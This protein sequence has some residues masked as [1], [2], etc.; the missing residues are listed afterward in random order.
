[1][2][3]NFDFQICLGLSL[4]HYA[5]VP[6]QYWSCFH[7]FSKP[8]FRTES[9]GMFRSLTGCSL[10]ILGCQRSRHRGSRFVTVP[11]ATPNPFALYSYF[12]L[13]HA[14]GCP[15]VWDLSLFLALG[16]FV[17]LLLALAYL[18]VKGEVAKRLRWQ[19]PNLLRHRMDCVLQH[20][21]RSKVWTSALLPLSCVTWNTSFCLLRFSFLALFH[22][23]RCST[24]LHT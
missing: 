11:A 23:G 7:V 15:C 8:T 16:D 5:S 18:S 20:W 13:C 10:V 1:M 19:P 3:W 6:E 24:L 17:I 21:L 12:S 14:S 2:F 9:H 22:F 4:S